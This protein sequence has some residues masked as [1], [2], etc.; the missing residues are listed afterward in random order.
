MVINATAVTDGPFLCFL[1]TGTQLWQG[2][3]YIY[4]RV[5]FRHPACCVYIYTQQMLVDRETH[6]EKIVGFSL[7][8]WSAQLDG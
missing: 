6:W 4:M 3:M 7:G 8:L 1:G 5:R 2:C